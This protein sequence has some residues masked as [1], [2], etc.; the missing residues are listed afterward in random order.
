MMPRLVTILSW[1][2]GILLP[3]FVIWRLFYRLRN[4]E[5][6]CPDAFPRRFP[7][8]G[9]RGDQ[10]RHRGHC[11]GRP[12]SFV[13]RYRDQQGHRCAREPIETAYPDGRRAGRCRLQQSHLLRSFCPACDRQTQN[14]A[15]RRRFRKLHELHDRPFAWRGDVNLW[16]G[17]LSRLF[18]L[19]NDARRYRQD[20]V[21]HRADVLAR[22]YFCSRRRH[23]FR[24]ASLKRCRPS[25][26]LNQSPRRL[27]RTF[28]HRLLF[29]LDHRGNARRRPRR[30]A[31]CPARPAWNA[32]ADRHR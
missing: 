22:Q 31:Y 10:P 30:L 18:V 27:R 23:R 32:L 5:F 14:A 24:A 3:R 29:H 6:P 8:Q 1:S 13:A 25:A 20:R 7:K 16:A 15:R 28:R 4:N 17:A 11:G 26:R 19:A 2:D 12:L 9:Q 21:F